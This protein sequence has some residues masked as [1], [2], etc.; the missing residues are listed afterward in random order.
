MQQGSLSICGKQ[1]LHAAETVG[2]ACCIYAWRCV[3]ALQ[4]SVLV[5]A[6]HRPVLDADDG[7]C[8]DS[9]GISVF[10]KRQMA[11]AGLGALHRARCHCS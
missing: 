2:Q 6:N 7:A 3:S 8:K 10:T 5:T 9:L 4:H 1:V 11:A